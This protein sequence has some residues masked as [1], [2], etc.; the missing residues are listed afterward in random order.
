MGFTIEDGIF[1]GDLPFDPCKSPAENRVARQHAVD[2]QLRRNFSHLI[3]DVKPE[4]LP[5]YEQ[6]PPDG[7][8]T[9]GK[10]PAPIREDDR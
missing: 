5:V 3:G 10:E 2:E 1:Y 8:M 9:A 7:E 4:P 6:I